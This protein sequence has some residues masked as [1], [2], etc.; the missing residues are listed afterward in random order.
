LRPY[1]RLNR[2]ASIL[3]PT[4]TLGYSP[5]S[6]TLC[7]HTDTQN[8]CAWSHS[9]CRDSAVD[10]VPFALFCFLLRLDEYSYIHS[11]LPLYRVGRYDMENA[12]FYDRAASFGAGSMSDSTKWMGISTAGGRDGRRND[13]RSSAPLSDRIVRADAVF[14]VLRSPSSARTPRNHTRARPS[15]RN[16]RPAC[17]HG[18]ERKEA[19]K[20]ETKPLLPTHQTPLHFRFWSSIVPLGVKSK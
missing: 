5:C 11:F 12:F 2:K 18:R 3:H 13:P 20:I 9:A 19:P 15:G 17:A 8:I 14:V 1:L 7:L 6:P 4:Y 10:R 16:R